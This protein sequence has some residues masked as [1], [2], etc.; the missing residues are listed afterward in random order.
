MKEPNVRRRIPIANE[1]VYNAPKVHDRVP[2]AKLGEP[3]QLKLN[4]LEDVDNV[5]NV[6][7]K[8]DAHMKANGEFQMRHIPKPVHETDHRIFQGSI[9]SNYRP[10]LSDTIH[11]CLIEDRAGNVGAAGAK[12]EKAMEG[13][14]IQ[15][16]GNLIHEDH[17]HHHSHRGADMGEI[18][19]QS[20]INR[21]QIHQNGL[22]RLQQNYP[23]RTGNLKRKLLR[24]QQFG[25]NFGRGAPKGLERLKTLHESR[26]KAF[27]Q[28]QHQ[29]HLGDTHGP[30]ENTNNLDIVNQ[31][32]ALEEEVSPKHNSLKHIIQVAPQQINL[33]DLEN[34]DNVNDVISALD[35]E[36]KA[37]VQPE[38]DLG[39]K[40][41]A[42]SD[43]NLNGGFGLH[44]RQRRGQFRQKLAQSPGKEKVMSSQEL[45]HP[46]VANQFENGRHRKIPW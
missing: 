31:I 42:Q 16:H 45:R 36:L 22:R 3:N 11:P 29:P 38:K 21:K 41:P 43:K 14:R 34:V 27:H 26:R 44:G 30:R 1:E 25:R 33:A 15:N 23:R 10:D 5:A 13:D 46:G 4:D 17:H 6:I 32:R 39:L 7:D 12:R 8:L 20:R 2:S 28:P 9:D 19:G 24:R 40:A 37:P 35:A 18:P